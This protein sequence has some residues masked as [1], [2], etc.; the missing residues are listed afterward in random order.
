MLNK[1]GLYAG[2]ALLAGVSAAG[3]EAALPTGSSSLF[4]Q[5]A[6]CPPYDGAAT[7]AAHHSRP[8][9][10]KAPVSHALAPPA[11]VIPAV[12]HP[13][14]IQHKPRPK[15]VAFVAP[16]FLKPT[17]LR[18]GRCEVLQRP[19]AYASQLMSYLPPQAADPTLS[20]SPTSVPDVT[21]PALSVPRDERIPAFAPPLESLPNGIV[22]S[23]PGTPGTP[24]T[25]ITPTT[26][27]DP[28]VSAVPEPGTWALMLVGVLGVGCALRRNRA[29]AVRSNDAAA[30]TEAL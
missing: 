18:P 13:H 19:D 28:P 26:P 25:P 10:H 21:P 20:S 24:T 11:V 3:A 4:A 29:S 9:L 2:A 7:P 22:P 17:V 5:E 8:H 23:T 30:S 27:S 12:V 6:P 15:R 16:A 14:P 1:L